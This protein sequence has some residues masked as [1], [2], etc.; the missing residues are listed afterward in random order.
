[1]SSL[2]NDARLF[3]LDL[4]PLGRDILTAWRGMLEWPVVSWLWPQ[5]R[6]RLWLPDGQKARS[7]GPQTPALPDIGKGPAAHFQALVLPEDI[8]LRRTLVMPTLAQA[9]RQAALALQL[10]TFS[11]FA[12]EDLVWT[13][14]VQASEDGKTQQIHAALT[15]RKLIATHL[16]EQDADIALDDMEVWIP[17]VH[18]GFHA[19]AAGFAEKRRHSRS[20]AWRWFS[21]A[22]FLLALAL[23]IA[24]LVTPTVQLYLR[25]KQ[26]ESALTALQQ[27]AMP[28]LAERESYTK[29]T[30]R[31][32]QAGESLNQSVAPL[33]VLQL[34]TETLGDDT[35]LNSLQ[36]Q[37]HKV[38]IAGQTVN[39]SVLM[40]KL[41]SQ[42]GLRDVRA[43]AP[44][45]KPLGA[46]RESFTIEFTM[47]PAQW[48]SV[49]T[50]TE[51]SGL[52]AQEPIASA[53]A[54]ATASVA[55]TKPAPAPVPALAPAPVPA[56]ASAPAKAAQA[57]PKSNP[58]PVPASP[59]TTTN[60]PVP[61][62]VPAPPSKT[63]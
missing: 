43:P 42:P 37:G 22:L 49:P 29:A 51:S 24:I 19:V 59:L 56:T 7:R 55:A 5:P 2:Q 31:L 61:A 41:G 8:L 20:T 46:T 27:K 9:E 21:A 26:A 14:E 52:P 57:S 53:S 11:P 10:Q 63:P 45:T 17:H 23:V 16:A 4:A 39:A 25:A 6:L 18:G 28:V 54:S 15:S 40:K 13:S 38:S 50:V 58:S 60:K 44:A 1:M 33:P 3:G 47:D 30:E 62:V 34:I 48:P 12:P 32:N 36:V 35:S